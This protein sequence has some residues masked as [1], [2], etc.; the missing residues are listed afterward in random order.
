MRIVFIAAGGD[1]GGPILAGL[2][3]CASDAPA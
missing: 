2:N 1:N 3:A